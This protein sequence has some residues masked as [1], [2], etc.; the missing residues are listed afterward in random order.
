[1]LTPA[2]MLS[3]FVLGVPLYLLFEFGLLTMRLA[4]RARG[5]RLQEEDGEEGPT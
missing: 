4:D 2:D 1:M 5:S 3:M